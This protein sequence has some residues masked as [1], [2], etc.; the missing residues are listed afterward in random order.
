MTAPNGRNKSS[1]L[2]GHGPSNSEPDWL[3]LLVE[4]KLVGSALFSF[5]MLPKLLSPQ[6]LFQEQYTWCVSLQMFATSVTIATFKPINRDT[7]TL[8]IP[9]INPPLFWTISR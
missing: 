1:Q 8:M 9:R 5:V 7:N 4:G 6:C 3:L 2:I